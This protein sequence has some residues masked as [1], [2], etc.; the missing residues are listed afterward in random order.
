MHASSQIHQIQNQPLVP[1]SVAVFC[2]GE[3]AQE[4]VHWALTYLTVA[5]S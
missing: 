2:F 3:K 5:I 1:H 4:L